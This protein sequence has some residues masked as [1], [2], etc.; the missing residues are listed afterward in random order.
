MFLV[1]ILLANVLIAI[2]AD[3]YK[4]IQDQRA[5]IVFWSNRLVFIAESDSVANGP[6]KRRIKEKIF[7]PESS[8]DQ[9]KNAELTFGRELWD[10]LMDLFQDDVDYGSMSA[11]IFLSTITRV[12]VALIVIPLWFIF[13]LLT[14]GSLWPPQIRGAIFTSNIRKHSSKVDEDDELRRRQT[15]ILQREVETLKEDLQEDL[16]VDRTQM[17]QMKSDVAER[18]QEIQAEMKKIQQLVTML[19]E[20]QTGM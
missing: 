13:G 16:A 5:A 18:K 6:W 12:F 15:R 14:F 19:F 11:D 2:V 9:P 10:Q 1:V 4:I 3:S 20:Q 7:G 8:N 17:M